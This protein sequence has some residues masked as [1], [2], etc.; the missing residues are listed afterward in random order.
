[1]LATGDIRQD[2]AAATILAIDPSDY[3]T[4]H[5]LLKLIDLSKSKD[6]L[7]TLLVTTED[8]KKSHEHVS[9]SNAKA[10]R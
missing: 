1:M 9:K 6:P 5:Q 4:T 3:V 7:I 2:P 8:K 10:R